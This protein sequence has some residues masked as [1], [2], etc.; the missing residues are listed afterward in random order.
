MLYREG[1]D[2][3]IGIAQPAHAWVSGQLARAWGNARFG[4]V[5]PRDAACL[6]AEQHDVG[7]AEWEGAP[8]LNPQTGRAYS[9]L[10]LPEPLHSAIFAAASRMLVTQNRYAALLASRHF[11]GLAAR[12]NL[13][14]DPPETARAIRAFLDTEGT[15][16]AE[17]LTGLR[18]DPD[19]AAHVTD[20]ALTRNSRLLAAWDWLSLLLLT[21]LR[22]PAEVPDVPT[23]DGATT[24]RL[25]PTDAAGT[26]VVVAPWPF[27]TPA[28]ALVCEGRQIGAPVADETVLRAGLVRAPWI[29]LRFTLRG[30]E[31]GEEGER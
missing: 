27:A 14:T 15:W 2:G 20:A 11:T 9:F 5:T 31:R 25:I 18:A 24:L 19:W 26:D 6:A 21:G 4:P 8:T 23:A 28:V 7:M 10:E 16:Q 12:H 30:E 29:T 1:A 3:T 13:T 22:G 17:I